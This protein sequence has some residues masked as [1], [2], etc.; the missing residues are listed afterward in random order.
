MV[1]RFLGANVDGCKDS[2]NDFAEEKTE[3][4]SDLGW[5][6]TVK[7]PTRISYGMDAFFRFD[8]ASYSAGSFHCTTRFSRLL[9]CARIKAR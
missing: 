4:K 9:L 8:E 5:T 6:Q 2:A 3:N 1:M 7:M